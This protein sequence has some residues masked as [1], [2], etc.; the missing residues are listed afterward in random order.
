MAREYL[1]PTAYLQTTTNIDMGQKPASPMI[2][3]DGVWFSY[4]NYAQVALAAS[5]TLP[6]LDKR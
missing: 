6:K 3:L 4:Q 1:M 5:N 2:L